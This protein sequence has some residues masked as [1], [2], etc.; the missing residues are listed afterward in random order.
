[1]FR[2]E[3]LFFGNES[4]SLDRFVLYLQPFPPQVKAVTLHE[5]LR[6]LKLGRL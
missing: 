3:I 6:H 4:Y 1:M 2:S 5:R